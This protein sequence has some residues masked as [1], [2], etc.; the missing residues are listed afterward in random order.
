MPGFKDVRIY[1]LTPQVATARRLAGQK[2]RTAVLYTCNTS[3]C[4]QLAQVVKA[5]LA[6]IN[7]DVQ[8][9]S[10]PTNVYFARLGRQG[11]P[12]DLAFGDWVA[13]YPDPDDF[14]NFLIG[15][16]GAGT[17]PPFEDSGYQRKV[18]TAA[19]LEGPV[20]FISYGKLDANVAR[21]DAPWVAFGNFGSHDFLSARMGCQ[22]YQ[23]VY[24]MDLAALCI[25]P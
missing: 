14:L 6:A 20:R 13:D 2:R 1:P 22:L 18:R 15:S 7:I 24:G 25:R 16:G 8:V 21:N 5:N 17:L 11:E 10:F 3:L 9:K 23:P 4:G 19:T 12:F